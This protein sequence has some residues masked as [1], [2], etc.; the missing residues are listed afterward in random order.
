MQEKCCSECRKLRTDE[1]RRP[2]YCV[3]QGYCDWAP[4]H[5]WKQCESCG[6]K[7]IR[8]RTDP[9]SANLTEVDLVCP[10]CGLEAIVKREYI[11]KKKGRETV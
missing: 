5:A 6:R 10:E 4:A 7:L 11:V 9:I 1:C 8:V 3:N 2:D